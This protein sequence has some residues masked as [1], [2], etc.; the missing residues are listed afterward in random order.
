M[1]Y[2][3]RNNGQI[4]DYWPDN[5]ESTLYLT[6]E[7]TLSDLISSITEHFGSS[8]LDKFTLSSEYIHTS[9]LTYDQYDSS[10]Y[11]NFIVIT[12]A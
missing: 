10:D 2:S 4:K 6:G 12:K 7:L 11:T 9:C 1:T 5:N 8:D 3:T